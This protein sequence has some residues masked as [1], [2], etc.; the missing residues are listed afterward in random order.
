MAELFRL[1]NIIIYQVIYIYICIYL[2]VNYG[3]EALC[4]WDD[5]N[6]VPLAIRQAGNPLLTWGVYISENHLTMVDLGKM[7]GVKQPQEGQF[8]W[9]GAHS[10]KQLRNLG[11]FWGLDLGQF[12]FGNQTW[13]LNIRFIAGKTLELNGWFSRKPRLMTPEGNGTEWGFIGFM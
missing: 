9:T 6:Q 13:Q 10:A 1:V 5:P 11:Y 3:Y 7:T 4:K 2:W 8:P 12:P